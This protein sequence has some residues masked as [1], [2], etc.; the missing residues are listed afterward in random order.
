MTAATGPLY[1]PSMLAL[2]VELSRH[3]F[4]A[5]APLIGEARAATC[6]STLRLSTDAAFAHVGLFVQACAVG[7]AAAA[8]FARHAA[9]A[10]PDRIR[11]TGDAMA[12]WL[13]GGPLPDW[14][15]IRLIEPAGAYPGRHGAILLPWRAAGSAMQGANSAQQP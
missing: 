1:T 6:G 11:A 15:D 5:G 7:Q 3:P 13:A 12:G 14:P 9:A 4:D 8:I 2:A 10:G